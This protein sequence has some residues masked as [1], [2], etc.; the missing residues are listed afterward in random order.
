MAR[1]DIIIGLDIGSSTIQCVVGEYPTGGEL[2][3]LGVAEVPSQGVRRG[4]VVDIEDASQA[5]RAAVEEAERS[6]GIPIEHAYVSIGGSH[7]SAEHSRGVVAVSRADQEISEED[8][9][10]AI[11]A[12]Q[13]LSLPPN[14][15]IIHVIP[16][17][18]KVDNEG[19]IKDPRGMSGVRLEVDALIVQ[20]ASPF[21]K[22]IVKCLAE[23]GVE[24][25]GLV[26]DILAASRAVL[27][28]RQKEIGVLLL[29][30][31]GGTCGTAVYE[32]GMI[33]S[34]EVLPVGASHITN[35]IAI[36][37]RTTIEIAEQIKLSFGVARSEDVHR[38]E[39]I[40]LSK[41][42]AEEQGEVSRKEIVDIIE[43][44]LVEVLDIVNK[45]LK[46]IGRQGM[47]PAGV[48]LVGGGVKI[49]QIVDL[50]KGTLKLPVQVGYPQELGGILDKVQD[51]SFATSVGLLLWGAD[52]LDQSGRKS[53]ALPYIPSLGQS[54]TK[55]KKWFRA[56]LP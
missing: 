23:V 8:I 32:E 12:A 52:M 22:N 21:V 42:S 19:G 11:Q 37:L 26:F 55:M 36:G 28:K 13:A 30:V 33:V 5:I 46:K 15:E 2:Q 10:R 31:G 40:K 47:L 44:R 45:G 18:F 35:D 43:A 16:R 38:R 9:H 25:D 48:V 17:A 54:I 41:I 56:F 29:D 51:P 49:P 3:I 1:N 24:P 27:S 20:A 7:V 53:F 4:V 39:T 6:S 34:A 50:A 14:R